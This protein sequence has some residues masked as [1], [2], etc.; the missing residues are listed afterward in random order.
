MELPSTVVPKQK[1]N[2]A[3]APLMHYCFSKVKLDKPCRRWDNL[4]FCFL[5]GRPKSIWSSTS[6]RCCNF[7][8]HAKRENHNKQHSTWFEFNF[9][10]EPEHRSMVPDMLVLSCQ[11]LRSLSSK[12]NRSWIYSTNRSRTR[13]KNTVG[14]IKLVL[15][16][17]KLGFGLMQCNWSGSLWKL[18]PFR[19][20]L[21]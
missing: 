6:Y 14:F 8:T 16:C 5:V 13:L 11:L 3:H 20:I 17:R 4:P 12:G 10:L 21:L 2:H 1:M 7:G 15:K 9:I 19:S 18:K